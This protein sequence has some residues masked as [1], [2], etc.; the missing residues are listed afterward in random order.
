MFFHICN[1]ENYLIKYTQNFMKT[2]KYK[3]NT[4]RTFKTSFLE[5]IMSTMHHEIQI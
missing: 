3:L 1:T 4:S 2:K 5:T